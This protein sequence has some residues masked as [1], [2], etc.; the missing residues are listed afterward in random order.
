MTQ[1]LTHRVAAEVR[2]E[3]ARQRVNQREVAKI[4]GVSQ[5]QVSQRLRGEIAFDTEELEKLA[6]A[7]QVSAS[8]FVP[9]APVSAA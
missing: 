7:F 3:M 6:R 8:Q 4:L 1:S 5:P 9:D 2:A